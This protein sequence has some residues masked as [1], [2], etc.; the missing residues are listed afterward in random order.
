MVNGA[1]VNW[2]SSCVRTLLVRVTALETQLQS[3]STSEKTV[4]S[5]FDHL[6]CS[7][8]LDPTAPVFLPT[9]GIDLTY[10]NS[11][12]CAHLDQPAPST[13]EDLH[14]SENL[15]T[16]E[17]DLSGTW[18]SLTCN[19]CAMPTKCKCSRGMAV[20]RACSC[21]TVPQQQWPTKDFVGKLV[22]AGAEERLLKKEEEEPERVDHD[23]EDE[24]E[25]EDEDEEERFNQHHNDELEAQRLRENKW[26]KNREL[27]DE[28]ARDMEPHEY[29]YAARPPSAYQ[30][31]VA[32][33][34][35]AYESRPG[36]NPA[37]GEELQAFAAAVSESWTSLDHGK[38]SEL[39]Q[40]AERIAQNWQTE[41]H[42]WRKHPR[43]SIYVEVR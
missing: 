34:A 10:D 33:A 8:V 12:S 2:L 1:A 18:E 31:F 40:L 37:N 27:A 11:I 39:E 15:E 9:C 16:H 43:R 22:E 38:H 24:V 19:Y 7:H 32:H 23:T 14:E 42:N 21:L 20:C 41:Q 25:D 13:G 26:R 3:K 36:R 4:I 29:P 5:I 17:L 35:R 28:R 30:I 6:P